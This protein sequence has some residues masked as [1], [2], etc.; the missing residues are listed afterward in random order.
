M[1]PATLFYSVGILVGSPHT[2]LAPPHTT[3][4]PSSP[5]ATPPTPPHAPLPPLAPHPPPKY[6][7]LVQPLSQ[8]LVQPLLQPNPPSYW[9][10][11]FK[12][13]ETL[14]SYTVHHQNPSPEP[15]YQNPSPEP[16]T[17]THHQNPSPEPITITS[18]ITIHHHQVL[19]KAG[20]IYEVRDGWERGR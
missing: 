5:H 2:P 6:G 10:F 17:R 8:P 12:K 9:V 3:M 7:V 20:F 18:T 4:H 14:R 11:L 19:M 13:R 15:H 1:L 16:V